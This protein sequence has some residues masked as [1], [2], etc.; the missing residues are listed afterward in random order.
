M[1][2]TF[3]NQN[4]DGLNRYEIWLENELNI[5]KKKKY[6]NW[7]NHGTMHCRPTGKGNKERGQKLRLRFIEKRAG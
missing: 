7:A 3:A 4:L 2:E 5:R 1:K 6:L